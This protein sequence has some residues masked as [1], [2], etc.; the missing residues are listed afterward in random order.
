MKVIIGVAPPPRNEAQEEV[1][2]YSP[3]QVED[4]VGQA[5][6]LDEVASLGVGAEASFEGEEERLIKTASGVVA[7]VAVVV[8]VVAVPAA[9]EGVGV[10]DAQHLEHDHHLKEDI[11]SVHLKGAV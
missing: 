6:G 4:Q 10:N 11:R 1:K 3:A 7:V 2:D 5:L 8:V 9:A